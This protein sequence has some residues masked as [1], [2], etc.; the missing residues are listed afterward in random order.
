M[1]S[2]RSH[3]GDDAARPGLPIG[4]SKAGRRPPSAKARDT[5]GGWPSPELERLSA[6]TQADTG[7]DDVDRRLMDT[8]PASDA[9]ARY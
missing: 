8:F 2:R 5:V 4:R 9:V 3:Y 7:Y 6:D 1:G